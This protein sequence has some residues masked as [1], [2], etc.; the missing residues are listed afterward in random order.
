MA[1]REA[2]HPDPLEEE[3]RLFYVALLRVKDEHYITY[4]IMNPKSYTGDIICRPSRFL[5]DF[6][7]ELV[8]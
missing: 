3:R 8:E 2:D 1:P 7:F 6:P 4:P 5:E